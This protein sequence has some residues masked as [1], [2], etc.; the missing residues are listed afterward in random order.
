M[1]RRLFG[2]T[3][4][5]REREEE[6]E[7]QRPQPTKTTSGGEEKTCLHY[8]YC[9]PSSEESAT[10]EDEAEEG[11]FDETI[12]DYVTK[13]KTL[14]DRPLKILLVDSVYS[15]LKISSRVL[16]S[17]DFLDDNLEGFQKH[18]ITQAKN[19]L[20]ALDLMQRFS[21]D[22]VFMEIK[23]PDVDGIEATKAQRAY[24]SSATALVPQRIVGLTEIEDDKTRR[25]ALDEKMDMY[26][27]KPITIEKFIEVVD[28]L[29]ERI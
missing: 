22:I 10:V 27:I 26:V 21:Y 8:F 9:F 18:Q 20:E 5:K 3:P 24:E 29:S 11:A 1:S 19:G 14:R 23:M 4:A 16:Q 7:K 17:M 13:S 15:H 6:R 12:T 2:P 28:E 25:R